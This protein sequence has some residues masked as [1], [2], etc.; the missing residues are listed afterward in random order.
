MNNHSA[1]SLAS[2]VWKTVR[3][4]T[5]MMEVKIFLLAFIIYAAF[6]QNYFLSNEGSRLALTMAVVENHSFIIDSFTDYTMGVDYSK[7]E[8]HYYSDKAPGASFIA[9]PAYLLTKTL[10]ITETAPKIFVIELLTTV[11]ISAA[12]C[13]IF[14]RFTGEFT[15]R[16]DSR[17]LATLAYGFGTML[18]PWSTL[19]INHSITATLLL[20]SFYFAHLVKEKKIGD[21]YLLLS[22]AFAGLTF[23]TEYQGPVYAIPIGI[24][25]M[26]NSRLK[27]WKFILPAALACS[28]VPA[29]NFVCFHNPFIFSYRYHGFYAPDMENSFYGLSMPKKE[30]LK[31]LLFDT[32]R[33]LFF[34]NPVL[35]MSLIGFVSLLY[36]RLRG[37]AFVSMAV[38]LIVLLC[39]AGLVIWWGGWSFGPRLLIPGLPFLC[40]LLIPTFEIERLKHITFTLLVLSLIA[41]LL[42]VFTIILSGGEDP[43]MQT[44]DN[45]VTGKYGVAFGSRTYYYSYMLS[46]NIP[47][48]KA[49]IPI[50]L[51]ISL[52][53]W[54]ESLNELKGIFRWRPT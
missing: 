42:G 37:E 43:L 48:W 45:A 33:G 35:L 24:Y 19:F 17:F 38:F 28:L 15:L 40:L 51:F 54:R 6:A 34:Y 23:I 41:M 30:A 53:F 10:G 26:W 49:S 1:I 50:I 8:D 3:E 14:Y 7:F 22:G 18:F 5:G 25:V 21:N 32:P 16:K 46:K 27:S 29:Y 39:T 2:S 12:G 31:G 47:V 11:L 13:A 9:I 44:I 52:I 36:S 4:L 20:A